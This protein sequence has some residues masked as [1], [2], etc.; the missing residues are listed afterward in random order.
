MVH[1]YLLE[2]ECTGISGALSK[3]KGQANLLKSLGAYKHNPGQKDMPAACWPFWVI[4]KRH[5]AKC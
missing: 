5:A 1:M 4:S 3:V 2:D